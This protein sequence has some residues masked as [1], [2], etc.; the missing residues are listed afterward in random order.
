[1]SA[2]VGTGSGGTDPVRVIIADD[3]PFAR[4]TVRD[5]LQDAGI[6]VIAEA[7]SG[8]DAVQLSVHYQPDVVLMDVVM[9]GMDGITATRK[10]LERAPNVR[11]L[12][13]SANADDE[14]GLL[15]L[16]SGAAGFLP[17]SM[18]VASL[19]R[20]LEAARNGEAVVSRQLTARLIEGLRRTPID[21]VGM[22]PVRS[23]LTP[24]E[25]EVLD[26]LCL[27]VTTD[28]IAEQLVLSHETVRSH[29]KNILRKLNVSSRAQA[30]EAA[31]RLRADIA[32]YDEQQAA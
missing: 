10:L 12:V 13:L 22:R 4:R 25:W 26:L 18:S 14:I 23:P 28:G 19:P 32:V 17:K 24:R 8:P 1:M 16:R 6:V 5:A 29:I 31:R 20:A 30:V 21:G 2:V 3:D 15:C 9:P 7:S 27:R 11:V